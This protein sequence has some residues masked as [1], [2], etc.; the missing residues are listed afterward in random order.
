VVDW[1]R[2]PADMSTEYVSSV[3]EGAC[4]DARAEL[5]WQIYEAQVS[6]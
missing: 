5:F 3:L 2:E 1:L 4:S 6:I